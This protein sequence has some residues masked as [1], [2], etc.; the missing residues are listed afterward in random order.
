[1]T[2]NERLIAAACRATIRDSETTLLLAVSY[3]IKSWSD[4]IKSTI[5]R[6]RTFSY[7]LNSQS[8][9]LIYP[10]TLILTNFFESEAKDKIPDRVHSL[11]TYKSMSVYAI[12]TSQIKSALKAWIFSHL[13]Y[14]I[15]QQRNTLVFHGR[16]CATFRQRHYLFTINLSCV[17][18]RDC[19]KPKLCL[20]L[21]LVHIRTFM[22]LHQTNADECN[23][24]KKKIWIWLL[25][26]INRTLWG[27][28]LES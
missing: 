13:Q 10:L 5:S 16:P 3:I 23:K 12:V 25:K 7:L 24:V 17:T 21:Y 18:T 6:T 1:M 4:H 27:W 8:R 22:L 2:V 15:F 14:L 11:Q 28:S 19:Y 9:P 26:C 20:Y